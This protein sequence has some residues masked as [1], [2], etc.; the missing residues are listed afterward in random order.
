ML[1]VTKAADGAAD[2][3]QSMEAVLLSSA[4]QSTAW[5]AE[6]ALLKSVHPA[7]LGSSKPFGVYIFVMELLTQFPCQ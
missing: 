2:D 3:T 6:P 1:G 5:A 7:L 4:A